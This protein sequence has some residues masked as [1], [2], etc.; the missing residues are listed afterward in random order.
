MKNIRTADLTA[1]VLYAGPRNF[2]T[3]KKPQQTGY[4]GH[5]QDRLHEAFDPPFPGAAQENH[6]RN[7]RKIL[8]I[9]N[10]R[11]TPVGSAGR[12]VTPAA[13]PTDESEPP[14]APLVRGARNSAV[15]LIRG[16]EG[17]V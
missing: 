14:L 6:H 9:C 10:L 17:V 15:P 16:I 7:F 2:A 5:F 3:W 13:S 12:R 1:Q 8:S 4:L 11:A